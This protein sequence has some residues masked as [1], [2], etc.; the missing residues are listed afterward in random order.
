MNSGYTQVNSILTNGGYIDTGIAKDGGGDSLRIVLEF[1]FKELGSSIQGL[2]GSSGTNSQREYSQWI[3]ATTGK[4]WIYDWRDAQAQST[5]TFNLNT[6]YTL[7]AI[8]SRYDETRYLKINNTSVIDMSTAG[9][10]GNDF[11]SHSTYLFAINAE[12]ND[13]K[14]KAEYICTNIRFYKCTIYHPSGTKVREYVPARRDSDGVYGL[15]DNVKNKFY[16]SSKFTSI[17]ATIKYNASGKW[18]DGQ[19]WYN[20]S[21][22]WKKVTRVWYNVNGVWK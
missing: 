10:S 7:D 17:P 14:G 15:Y 12:D 8:L 3:G 2:F 21:G 5:T 18:K 19:V 20:V 13:G 11:P 6:K 22:A 4:K 9:L 1:E 16:A